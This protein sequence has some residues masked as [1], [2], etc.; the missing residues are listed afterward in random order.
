MLHIELIRHVKVAGKAGLYGKTDVLPLTDENALLLSALQRRANSDGNGLNHANKNTPYFDAVI[1]SPLKRCAIIANQFSEIENVGLSFESDIQEMD[2]GLYD[3]LSFD[4]IPFDP[5]PF[6]S[7][8]FEPK[9]FDS[10]P[11]GNLP[12]CK[13]AV[14]ESIKDNS[15]VN[16]NVTDINWTTLE[17][18]FKAPAEVTLPKAESLEFFHNRV[19]NAWQNLISQQLLLL[20][21]SKIQQEKE[22]EQKQSL[23]QSKQETVNNKKVERRVAIFAHGGVIRMILAHALEI[24]WQQAS[25]Y[26]N[27]HI[28]YASLSQ[29]SI[30]PLSKVDSLIKTQAQAQTQSEEYFQQVNIIGSP[31]ISR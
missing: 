22:Q 25:W 3:G 6:D 20:K 19:I 5:K 18:F 27:L 1:S 11:F 17:S 7:A 12:S 31:L 9:P 23:H 16:E 26:Q 10:S 21:K 28:D 13:E 24:N 2:F 14:K 4:S 8:P 15:K 29:I 30:T